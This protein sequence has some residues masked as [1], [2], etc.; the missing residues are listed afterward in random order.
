MPTIHINTSTNGD[1]LIPAPGERKFIRVLG[2]DLT[3][4]NNVTVSL[5]S[6]TTPIWST[7]AMVATGTDPSG[8]GIVIK[9]SE[10]H[11]LD[12]QLNQPLTIGLSSSVNVRGSLTYTIYGPPIVE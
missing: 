4:A 7:N 8:S 5:R 10:L 2:F 3:A 11:D 9:V 6:N 1:V 12:C